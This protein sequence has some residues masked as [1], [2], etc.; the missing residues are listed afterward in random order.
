MADI[1]PSVPCMASRMARVPV[2]PLVPAMPAV[3]ATPA[4]PSE[5]SW[6]RR[7]CEERGKEQRTSCL[8]GYLLFVCLLLLFG[9]CPLARQEAPSAL[10]ALALGAFGFGKRQKP[11]KRQRLRRATASRVAVAGGPGSSESEPESKLEL[12]SEFD[13][14]DP[15]LRVEAANQVG[16]MNVTSTLWPPKR[17]L[18]WFLFV[19][20][21]FP[22][23][24]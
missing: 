11:L 17:C 19:A 16:A 3:P 23:I 24:L 12:Q 4:T 5:P 13:A 9:G 14:E 20:G 18:D 22:L 7:R 1:G 21:E 6:R 10:G 2:M 15:E 8:I